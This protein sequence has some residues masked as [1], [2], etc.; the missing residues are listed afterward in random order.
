MSM[1]FWVKGL[2]EQI[3]MPNRYYEP[4]MAEDSVLNPKYVPEPVYAECNMSNTNAHVFC[5]KVFGVIPVEGVYNWSVD[6]LPDAIEKLESAL[7]TN[8]IPAEA[9]GFVLSRV[10]RVAAVFILA[11]QRQKEVVL[12]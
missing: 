7:W 4:N 10:E 8:R 11:R 12:A 6:Q 3:Q 2:E 5:A 9:R 1:T